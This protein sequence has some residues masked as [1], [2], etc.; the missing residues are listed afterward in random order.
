MEPVP[1]AVRSHLESAAYEALASD[2]HLSYFLIEA[3]KAF[4]LINKVYPKEQSNA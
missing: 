2:M 1:A 3:A 4:D